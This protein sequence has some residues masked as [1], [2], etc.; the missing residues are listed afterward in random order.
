MLNIPTVLNVFVMAQWDSP[1]TLMN[2][3]NRRV[4]VQREDMCVWLYT[5]IGSGVGNELTPLDEIVIHKGKTIT[6]VVV[7]CTSS[8]YSNT[9]Y[10]C[11][12]TRSLNRCDIGPQNKSYYD[13][14]IS[15]WKQ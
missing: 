14:I 4:S 10:D 15:H 9:R 3:Y 11:L 7:H 2:G 1:T 5:V 8:T 12:S 6:R 13:I